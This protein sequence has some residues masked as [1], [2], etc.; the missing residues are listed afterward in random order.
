M[1]SAKKS[2]LGQL[3]QAIENNELT[4]AGE[5]INSLHPSEVARIL[6]SLPQ[7]ERAAVWNIVNDEAEGEILVECIEEVRQTLIDDMDADDVLAATEG[8]ELDDL[9][10]IVPDL[11]AAVTNRVIESLSIEDREHLEAALSFPEDS[12]GGL[13][14]PDTIS[15]RS[16]VTLEVVWRYLR[17]SG[18]LPDDS[19]GI[20]VVDRADT[21]LG[22]LYI[23]KLITEE[24]GRRVAEVMDKSVVPISCDIPATEV[25]TVFQDH[26]L[27]YAAVI[28]DAGKLI[29]Q[30]TV[31]DVVDVI[32]EQADH[33][34]LS[35]AG[36]DED[37][38]MFAPVVTSAR[39]R[40]IWLGVNLGTAFLA[41]GVVAIFKPVLEQVVI[42]AVLMPIVASMGGIAGSQTL[43]LMIRGMAMGRVQ[44][45]NAQWLLGKEIAVG[46]LNGLAWSLVVAVATVFFFSTL[47]VGLI[48]GAALIITL[49]TAAFVGFAIPLVLRKM[50]ID[51]ALAGTVILTT[52]TDV[53]G[54]ATFLGLGTIFLT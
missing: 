43:T 50:H 41:A 21:Y 37:D 5:L 18:E 14:D 15:V 30:I 8:M 9:A 12:A 40:A 26:D 53:V 1:E 35:M 27:V 3:R 45:S 13:M 6:E 48:I 7:P 46:L 54:F 31:D 25:G 28:D 17:R 20:F 39:R 2:H 51:P 42:L 44:D 10:D 23:S 36:L 19:P 33:D 52:V 29:G 4:S 34:I 11:P 38:D 16:D 32:R 47:E 24:P 22:V 49:L